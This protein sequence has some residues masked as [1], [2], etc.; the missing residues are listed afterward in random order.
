MM[1]A[2][3]GIKW[4]LLTGLALQLAGLGTLYGWQDSWSAPDN[5]WKGI[6][7]V[8]CAQVRG[9]ERLAVRGGSL[10]CGGWSGGWGGAPRC[11]GSAA[12]WEAWDWLCVCE[13]VRGGLGGR[14]T[15]VFT[16]RRVMYLHG[17]CLRTP[18]AQLRLSRF[19]RPHL[20]YVVSR[21]A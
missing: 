8:T 4:T 12:K 16:V 15:C 14:L 1:G 17:R 3:W 11:A 5:R 7:F 10:G 21:A 18:F 19:R 9:S 2:R 6:L 20:P 13:C